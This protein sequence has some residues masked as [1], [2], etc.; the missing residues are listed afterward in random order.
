MSLEEFNAA[1]PDMARAMARVWADIPRWVDDVVVG[2]PYLDVALAAAAAEKAASDWTI[3][4]LDAALA[5]HPRIGQK[6]SGQGREAAESRREQASMAGASAELATSMAAANAAYE[7][8]FGRIFLIRAAGRSPEEM[9][10]ELQRRLAN[11]E[12]TEA[13]EAVE[14]LR[15]IALLR[16]RQTLGTTDALDRLETVRTLSP[17][18]TEAR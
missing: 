3:E 15:Q 14:Q 2:R 11:D 4:D 17:P 5:H 18:S 10:A 1:K 7:E 6:A 12:T 13:D 16:L 8:R 9:L